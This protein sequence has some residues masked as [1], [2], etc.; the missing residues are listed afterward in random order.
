MLFHDLLQGPAESFLDGVLA[1]AP[2]SP[3]L[4]GESA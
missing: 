4:A 1:E 3:A 2:Q